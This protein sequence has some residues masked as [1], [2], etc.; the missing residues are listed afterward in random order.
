MSSHHIVREKQE[1]ALLV[2]NLSDFSFELLGQLL[3][4]SPTLIAIPQ[5]AIQLHENQIKVDWLIANEPITELQSDVKLIPVEDEKYLQTALF[6]L[7][8]QGYRAVNVITNNFNADTY[9]PY[10]SQIDL[11]I[12]QDEEKIYPIKSGFSKWKPA[13]DIIR[14]VTQSDGLNQTGLKALNDGS[15]ETMADGFFTIQ[16]NQPYVFIAERV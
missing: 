13:G 9:L 15:F 8:D 2:L 3:E 1:P 11:V 12:Y 10:A 4:W 7:I 5:T 14:F 6:Q 16:F